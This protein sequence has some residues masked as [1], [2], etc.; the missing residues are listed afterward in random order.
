MRSHPLLFLTLLAAACS[1]APEETPATEAPAAEQPEKAPD[2]QFDKAALEAAPDDAALVPSPA[3]MQRTLANAGL[4]SKLGEMVQDR[5]IATAVDN[6]DQAAV[7]TGV[8]LAALVLTV[9]TAPKERQL[10][11]LARL[12]EGFTKMG[13]SQDILATIDDVS[14]RLQAD[15]VSRDDLLKEMD[16]LSGVMVPE[17]QFEGSDWTVPLI[18]AGTWLEGSHLVAGAV[19]SEGK[20]EAADQLLK[21]P[22]VVEHFLKYVQHEG[23]NKAPDEVV[24]KLE[25][26]LKTLKEVTAKET[27]TAEDVETIHSATGA[28]LALL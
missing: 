14:G 20:V 7:R 24:D 18:Q 16:E 21:Q 19:K 23:R 11:E 10:A 12:K 26:T 8:V 5:D 3:E 1:G 17:L 6:K 2:A 27:L 25:E 13:A 9:Q 28:V 22:T 4:T 15:A